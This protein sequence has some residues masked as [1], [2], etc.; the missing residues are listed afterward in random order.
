M[1]VPTDESL[2]RAAILCEHVASGEEPVRLATKDAPEDP[3]DSG[4]QFLCNSGKEDRVDGAQVW[5]LSE[6]I[7]RNPELASWLDVPVGT[8]LERQNEQS[9]WSKKLP[10]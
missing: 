6:V 10:P 3:A 1:P 4:W 2:S 8:C 9:A 7:E 5:L